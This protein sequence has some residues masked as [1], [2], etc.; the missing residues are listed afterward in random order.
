M[1]SPDAGQ[2]GVGLGHESL[3]LLLKQLVR[4]L[5]C[6]RLHGSALG[7]VFLGLALETPIPVLEATLTTLGAV[8]VGAEIALGTVG[9]FICSSFAIVSS[10][11]V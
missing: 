4:G 8:A 6:G 2:L 3:Q 1:V 7:T 5:G 9:I 11:T 10:E